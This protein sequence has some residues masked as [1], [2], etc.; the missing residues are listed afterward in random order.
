MIRSMPFQKIDPQTQ[1][2]KETSVVARESLW[3]LEGPSKVHV[4]EL[5]LPI[6][7]PVAYLWPRTL[8]PTVPRQSIRAWVGR[9]L[10][11]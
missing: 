7:I 9:G 11:V 6:G 8:K 1:E 4:M 2:G 3:H 10:K 5:S